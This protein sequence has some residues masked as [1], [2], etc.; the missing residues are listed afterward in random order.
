VYRVDHRALALALVSFA[1]FLL[2][3]CWRARVTR[4]P[5]RGRPTVTPPPRSTSATARCA[6]RRG[7]PPEWGP[8]G[9]R[10][11]RNEAT[12]RS[13]NFLDSLCTGGYPPLHSTTASGRRG[14]ELACRPGRAHV[15]RP[16]SP[17]PAPPLLAQ[18]D[19]PTT[20]RE[21]MRPTRSPLALVVLLLW[22]GVDDFCL[23]QTLANAPARAPCAEDDE[24]SVSEAECVL[25]RS[26]QAGGGPASPAGLATPHLPPSPPRPH[27]GYASRGARPG[28]LGAGPPL[29]PHVPAPV[30]AARPPAGAG[31]G[32]A[33]G[34]PSSGGWP[35]SPLPGTPSR[36]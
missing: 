18:R 17:T 9:S 13:G 26:A 27:P 21:A 34:R 22:A 2:G 5:R 30:R 7:S 6:A 1:L 20:S 12:K 11:K 16:G 31:S 35:T 4:S 3:C 8:P 33:G 24:F 10:K 29:P 15:P 36:V 23:P 19:Q 32:C 28:V 25:R 14:G